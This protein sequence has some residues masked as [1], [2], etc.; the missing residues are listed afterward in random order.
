MSK[1]Y[2]KKN[3]YSLNENLENHGWFSDKTGVYIPFLMNFSYLKIAKKN[4][5]KSTYVFFEIKE[6]GNGN[7]NFKILSPIIT[8][9]SPIT[10]SNIRRDSEL[11]KLAIGAGI[12]VGSL[13]DGFSRTELQKISIELLNADCLNVLK[14]NS[15][16][17]EEIED[18]K[19]DKEE[20]Y[21]AF[22]DYPE[23]IREEALKIINSGNI[24]D[25]LQ[26][27]VGTLH[28]GD[29]KAG[30]I[31]LLCIATLFIENAGSVHET[32]KGST[33]KGKSG[34]TKKTI[35]L[36]PK[37][38]VEEIRDSSPKYIYYACENG[39]YHEKYNI[40]FYDDIVLN[41]TMITIIKTLADNLQVKK[42]L[43]TVKDQSVLIFEI[44]G[45]CLVIMSFAKE[46]TDEE[47]NN[48][49][50]YN[51]PQEDKDH[52]KKTKEK[53]RDNE[54]IGLNFEDPYVKRLYTIANAVM[55]YIIDKEIRVYNPY[56]DLL[57][58]DDKSYRE[59]E[60][61]V[62]LIKGNLFYNITNR[63][64]IDG[65]YIGN[66][67]DVEAVTGIW[68]SNSL[69]QQYKIDAKQI[70][71]IKSLPIY[72]DSLFEEQKKH[73]EEDKDSLN[74]TFR[75][76]AGKSGF[77]QN[78]I[79]SWVFGR[80]DRESN[81]PTMIDQDLIKAIKLEPETKNS[82][83]VLYRGNKENL[84]ELLESSE[85][86]ITTI[87]LESSS[88]FDSIN[89]KKKVIYGFLSTT[90][91]NKYLY[92]EELLDNFLD[93]EPIESYDDI[94]NLIEESINYLKEHI[95]I[96]SFTPE[97]FDDL[98]ESLSNHSSGDS[99]S[100]TPIM[101]SNDKLCVKSLTPPK[102]D[103][104]INTKIQI[105]EVY[106]KI[107]S[108]LIETQFDVDNFKKNCSKLS[109]NFTKKFLNLLKS[110]K[111]DERISLDSF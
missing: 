36:V 21:T 37:Q 99:T 53:I 98:I 48:R 5:G 4:N 75:A 38:Y 107:D 39:S 3:K 83:Y 71:L 65:V 106:D 100:S 111:L 92:N 50:F 68:K 86:D 43:K 101:T 84:E 9:K 41:D 82:P 26:K 59:V 74:N 88:I 80:N 19:E 44:P 79:K 30:K 109:D 104:G 72:S 66:I 27:I 93:D 12:D 55:Q 73:Y 63:K 102:K 24:M 70:E 95:D 23:D 85:S 22:D 35:R 14:T 54:N 28:E 78:T 46:I 42:T 108:D 87:T 97:T 10:E 60:F 76:L 58:L 110:F 57:G 7:K 25:S 33:G 56:I 32:T 31:L 105:R 11:H 20:I 94:C 77:S 17:Y 34:L 8:S 64:E 47:L 2:N 90:T 96:G 52:G 45:K 81:K 40:F 18:T 49:L 67:E 16:D 89:M 13:E 1:K 15:S 6:D 29:K 91:N 69:M 103:N 51:N 61:A 62:N